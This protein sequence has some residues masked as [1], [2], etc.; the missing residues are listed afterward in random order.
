MNPHNTGLRARCYGENTVSTTVDR[1][2][3]EFL[4]GAARRND[5]SVAEVLRRLI[6]FY[7]TYEEHVGSEVDL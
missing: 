6:D 1:D 4:K 7:S 2:T 5:V 3:R